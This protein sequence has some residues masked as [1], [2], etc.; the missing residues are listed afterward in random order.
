MSQARIRVGN[1]PPHEI[2]LPPRRGRPRPLG[3]AVTRFDNLSSLDTAQY[4]FLAVDG[5]LATYCKAFPTER[6]YVGG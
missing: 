1:A 5:H 3:G 4:R 6:R 2:A